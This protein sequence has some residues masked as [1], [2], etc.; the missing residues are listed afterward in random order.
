[1]RDQH[2]STDWEGGKVTFEEV[3]SKKKPVKLKL[4]G[5]DGNAFG[6]LAAFRRQA[7]TEGWTPEEVK[8]VSDKSMSG[9]YDQLLATLLEVTHG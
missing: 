1:M 2:T 4:V 3:V 9:D 5:M 7:R 8:V 6:L